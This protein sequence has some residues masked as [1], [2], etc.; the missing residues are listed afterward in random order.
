MQQKKPTTEHKK[1]KQ[2][3]DNLKLLNTTQDLIQVYPDRF[4]GIG[5]IP[6]TYHITL[7]NDAKSVI[8]TPQKCPIA[9]QPLVHEKLNEFLE[10]GIITPVEESTDWVS[11]LAYSWKAKSLFRSLRC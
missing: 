8:H 10:Q 5:Y 11:S 2:D 1:V 4:K 3:L 9:M 6:G 7:H